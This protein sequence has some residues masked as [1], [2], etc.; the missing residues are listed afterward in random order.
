MSQTDKITNLQYTP[1]E[2]RAFTKVANDAG[3]YVT[4][5]AYTPASIRNAVE[6]GVSGIEH[7]N[8]LDEQTAKYM[9]SKGVFLTPTL[10]TYE[11][12][13]SKDFASFLPPSIAA[14]NLEIL[15][16]GLRSVQIA[17]QAGVT[18]CY[19]TDLLGPL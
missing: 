11:T 19:G 14:K 3:T 13:A 8:L 18:M 12:M 1:E 2:I 10:V 5:H 9:A 6:Q 4:A 17:D 7:G 15:N 16:A